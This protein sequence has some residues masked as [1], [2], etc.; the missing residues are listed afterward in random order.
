MNIQLRTALIDTT[1]A[2][3]RLSLANPI[4]ERLHSIVT[5]LLD[6][7]KNHRFT[8]SADHIVCLFFVARLTALGDETMKAQCCCQRILCS[9]RHPVLQWNHALVPHHRVPVAQA[10]LIEQVLNDSVTEKQQC[11]NLVV[12]MFRNALITANLDLIIEALQEFAKTEYTDRE[13]LL[14]HMEPL[15]YEGI[16]PQELGWIMHCIRGVPVP[17]REMAVQAIM[18]VLHRDETPIAVKQNLYLAFLA[19]AQEADAQDIFSSPPTLRKHVRDHLRMILQRQQDLSLAVLRSLL[20]FFLYHG[21]LLGITHDHPMIEE[22][23]QSLAAKG[24]R[25]IRYLQTL[26]QRNAP[27]NSTI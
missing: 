6:Q 24:Y 17:L 23:S 3:D 21:F 16:S 1:Q 4:E 2:L 12:R 5:H 26:L 10:L 13:N 20:N 11:R 15:L 25:D 7:L 8:S 27:Q 22:L 14:T 19:A 9:R 18:M